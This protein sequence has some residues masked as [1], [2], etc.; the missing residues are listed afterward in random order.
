M[1]DNSHDL[2]IGINIAKTGDGASSAA[3]DLNAT[4]DAA[5]QATGAVEEHGNAHGKMRG[6][7]KGAKEE[8]HA[9]AA[10]LRGDVGDAI[11]SAGRGFAHLAGNAMAF[12]GITAVFS[13][14]VGGIVG[15]VS[16]M[17]EARRE[18]L[19]FVENFA[20][21]QREVNASAKYED[22][23]AGLDK[24]TK[25]E[26]A[27]AEA[28]E[29]LR[30]AQN[31]LRDEKSALEMAR[32]DAEEG[33]ALRNAKGP[34]ERERIKLQFA[35][36][37]VEK[38]RELESAKAQGAVDDTAAKIEEQKRLEIAARKE[39]NAAAAVAGASQSERDKTEAQARAAGIDVRAY[40]GAD[41]AG[42]KKMRE[43]VAID[44]ENLAQSYTTDSISAP[45]GATVRRRVNKSPEQLA[46]DRERASGMLDAA[47]SLESLPNQVTEANNAEK[48]LAT[49]KKQREEEI[50]KSQAK[51][52]Q[53]ALDLDSARVHQATVTQVGFRRQ[54][55]VAVARNEYGEKSDAAQRAEERAALEEQLKAEQKQLT[56]VGKY[57]REGTGFT[58]KAISNINKGINEAGSSGDPTQ[59]LDQLHTATKS[60]DK[61][62]RDY[63]QRQLDL[64]ESV[65]QDMATLNARLAALSKKQKTQSDDI[66]GAN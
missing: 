54:A 6:V 4:K 45:G 56:A 12:T 16:K 1:S 24:L 23:I 31:K 13:V 52:E 49:V 20:R 66:G 60:S 25:A 44:A 39:I 14:V 5:K 22:A 65:M 32:L 21:G 58:G 19:E 62:V 26:Q 17:A 41:E 50:A 47:R 34:E 15:M 10:L 46:A 35:Q 3:A 7:M 9:L 27:A 63:A 57:D 59:A 11:S 8:F 30:T 33:T 61:T 18:H 36:A 43:E 55:D 53:L 37:R 48:N 51:R 2:N 28:A 29:G 64:L 40:M 38:E 42:R